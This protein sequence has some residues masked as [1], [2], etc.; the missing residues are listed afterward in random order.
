MSAIDRPFSAMYCLT[1]LVV[2]TWRAS[3]VF[4]RYTVRVLRIICQAEMRIQFSLLVYRARFEY[5]MHMST[6]TVTAPQSP[7]NSLPFS[8]IVAG[9]VRAACARRGLLAAELADSLGMSRSAMSSRWRGVRQWQLE[10]LE[11]VARV[12]GTTPW[13][14][15]QPPADGGYPLWDSNPRPSD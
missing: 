13:A 5:T 7:D 6:L 11:A 14:L 8:K 12:L 4:I 3:N 2:A 10:D 15:T 1:A 9:N